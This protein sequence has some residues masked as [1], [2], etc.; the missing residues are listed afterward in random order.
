MLF[1]QGEFFGT[2]LSVRRGWIGNHRK[3]Y[4]WW[5]T[6]KA[7]Q[8]IPGKDTNRYLKS[9]RNDIGSLDNRHYASIKL[10][11]AL[12]SHVS[13]LIAPNGQK[14]NAFWTYF[15]GI[16]ISKLKIYPSEKMRVHEAI[17]FHPFEHVLAGTR[18][19]RA[20]SSCVSGISLD[21]FCPSWVWWVQWLPSMQ[22]R[23][24]TK[25]H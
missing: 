6:G 20:G 24:I 22:D 4:G 12:T 17:G 14:L 8:T 5:Y 25:G 21:L 10:C 23:A 11:M 9:G 3:L 1:S 15:H 16:A 19:A 13:L 18:S 2:Y 7:I